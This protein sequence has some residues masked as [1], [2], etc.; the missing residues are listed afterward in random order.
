MLTE[1]LL[2]LGK[3]TMKYIE[4]SIQLIGGSGSGWSVPRF[5]IV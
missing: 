1:L 2:D 4:I 3:P 5:L